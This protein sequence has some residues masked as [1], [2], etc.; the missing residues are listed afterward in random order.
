MVCLARLI[1]WAIV[2]SGTRKALAISAVV[3]PPIARNVSAIADAP[4]GRM[5]AHEEQ[6]ER[7]ILGAGFDRE[8]PA[9]HSIPEA[10]AV[11]RCAGARSRCADV[12]SCAV[13][14]LGSASPRGLPGT[15]SRGH[16]VAP[17]AALPE[18]RPRRRRNPEIDGRRAEHLRRQ[19]AQQMFGSCYPPVLASWARYIHLRR[20]T[21]H[22]RPHLNRHVQAAPRQVRA[23]QRLARLS[24]KLVPEIRHRRSSSREKL[25]ALGKHSVGLRRSVLPSPHQLGLIW[26]GQPFGR[27]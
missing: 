24:R 10:T 19:F 1:R 3:R 13:K 9:D 7:V 26:K 14:Q 17:R 5:A 18:P 16:C 25:L 6:D 11:S 22:H 2:A 4:Q 20:R 12:Q 15:P 8:Q 27:D 21:A 23:P